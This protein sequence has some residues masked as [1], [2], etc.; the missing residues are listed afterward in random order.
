MLKISITTSYYIYIPSA[1]GCSEFT[2]WLLLVITLFTTGWLGDEFLSFSN[3]SPLALFCLKILVKVWPPMFSGSLESL[4][5]LE[6][7]TWVLE[8]K[9]VIFSV[10][11][12]FSHFYLTQPKLCFFLLLLGLR[13]VTTGP[14]GTTA[15]APKFQ[16][17]LILFRPGPDEKRGQILP[18][19]AEVA[20]KISPWIHPWV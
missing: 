15:I 18:I 17:I 8:Y 11:L 2:T 5:G 16:D 7:L 3:F 1:W 9:Y 13:D 4:R 12:N 6:F 14:S 10:I 20:P 19:I